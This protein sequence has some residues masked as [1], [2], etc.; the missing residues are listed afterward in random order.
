MDERRISEI[1]V[2]PI[3]S[4][5]GIALDACDVGARGLAMDRLWMVV[6]DDGEFITGREVPMLTQIRAQP[7]DHGLR[8]STIG[9]ADIDIPVPVASAAKMRVNIWDDECY[10]MKAGVD[11]DEWFSRALGT[12][13]HLVYMH[14]ACRRP[15]DIDYG[16]PGDQVS[17][18]DGFPLLLISTASLQDLNARLTEPVSMR[19]FRPNVVV[20]GCAPYEED[21]WRCITIGDI[22]FDVV[23]RC[24][25]CV[26]TTID[27]DSGVEHPRRE[28]LR[29]LG[30]YRRGP[31]G[32]ILFGQNLIP[33]TSGSIYI[34]DPVHIEA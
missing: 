2:F 15:V 26:F 24:S 30:T 13:C 10:A 34:G 23:E 18:A 21:G 28:P 6:D 14:D 33:R 16:R 9:S 5:A 27:P 31:D 7:T 29:T 4:T 20:D 19:R 12:S 22:R 11:A 32:G 25:R 1:T 3:K 8:V 17:F